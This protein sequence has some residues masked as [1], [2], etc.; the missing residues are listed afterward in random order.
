LS[1]PKGT[2]RNQ[3]EPKIDFFGKWLSTTRLHL[4]PVYVGLQRGKSARQADGHG[5]LTTKSARNAQKLLYR[6]LYHAGA[7]RCKSLIEHPKLYLF[8]TNFLFSAG[9]DPILF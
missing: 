3:K 8:F 4:I 7:N 6:F 1:E 5:Y 9:K 2:K